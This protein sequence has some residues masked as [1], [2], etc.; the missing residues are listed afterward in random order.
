M[1]RTKEFIRWFGE[2]ESD[3]ENSSRVVDDN[4]EP[5]VVYHGTPSY[6][7][8]EFLN[9]Y[10]LPRA[11]SNETN[12]MGI[13]FSSNKTVAE[14][15][16]FDS[17]KGG[18]YECFLNIRNP[19]VFVPATF[20]IAE[21][22]NMD[23]LLEEIRREMRLLG[24]FMRDQSREDQAKLVKLRDQEKE[25][26][27]QRKLLKRVDSFEQFMNYRDKFTK[28]IDHVEGKIGHWIERMMNMNKEEANKKLLKEF[29]DNKHDGM[30]I[31][32]T[33]YDAGKNGRVTQFC[34][35]DAADIKS[36]K[37]KGRF[38]PSTKNIYERI[39][40]KGINNFDI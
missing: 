26:S 27:F 31:V 18:V 28:Y 38:D 30:T 33:E 19:K 10:N 4:G 39:R 17:D 6:G 22:D 9:D 2:W 7:F 5:W 16:M 36:V 24:G 8:S 15:F 12:N 11:T 29:T 25:L 40:I 14:K 34:V 3:P 23:K 35:F 21:I 32:D 37:N 20:N 13:W 1:V